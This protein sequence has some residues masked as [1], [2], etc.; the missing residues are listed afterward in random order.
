[1]YGLLA[2]VGVGV[3][4]TTTEPKVV[5]NYLIAC[6]IADIG[7]LGVTYHVMGHSKFLDIAGWNSMAWGNIGLTAMLF[8]VRTGYL[9]GLFGNKKK[10]S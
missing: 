7:H 6:T 5:R 3:L 9:M 1:M 10:I 4:Y 8:F 2:L